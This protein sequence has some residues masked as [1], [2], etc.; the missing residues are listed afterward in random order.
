FIERL[1]RSLKYEEVYLHAYASLAEAKAGIG[2]W[3]HF[4][5]RGTAA[6]EPRLPHAA[7]SL[8]GRPVD[9][10]TIGFADRLRFPSFPSQL[11][12]PGNARLRPHPHRHHS[13]QRT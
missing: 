8:R 2:T 3:L 11:G 1:W 5:K 10:W 13:Q 12:K 6:S 7:P 4:Y 9:M